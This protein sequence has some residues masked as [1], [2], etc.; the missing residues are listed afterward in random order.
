MIYDLLPIIFLFAIL[1]IA[2]EEKIK[3][4]KSAIMIMSA[5]LLWSLLLI[6][7]NA[8]LGTGLNKAYNQFIIDNPNLETLSN[9]DK[10]RYY[11]TNHAFI[12]NLGEVTTTLFFV[13]G[14]MTIV[15][16]IQVHGGF[17]VI[18]DHLNIKTKRQFAWAIGGISFVS[19]M[20]LDD[21]AAA[22]IMIA[23]LR[24]FFSTPQ[25]RM[26]YSCLVIITCNAGG[27]CSPIGD[28]TTILLW[29]SGNISP[30]HQ[31]SH[32]LIPSL[33][34]AVVAISLTMFFIKK[35]DLMPDKSSL[36]QKKQPALFKTKVSTTLLVMG[37]LTL[38]LVPV[39]NEITDLPPFMGVMGGLGVMWFYTDIIYSKITSI[40]EVDR[41]DMQR[42]LTHVDM[43]TIMFFFGVL[44]SVAALKTAGTLTDISLFL[45]KNI[46]DTTLIAFILGIASSFLDNVALVA[47]TM[48]MYPL[49]TITTTDT[50]LMVYATNSEFW[51]FIAYC[52]VTGGSIL[53]IG[54]A[55][56]VSVMGME[57]IPFGYYLK[58]FSL[59][60]FASYIAGAGAYLLIINKL[61]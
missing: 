13:I 19:S 57:K 34:N 50:A 10:Y 39:F 36:I 2:F 59:I 53:I 42:I 18:S 24:A 11:L 17:K 48:G 12:D 30:L 51:T 21:L 1:G 9:I 61:L 29:T 26:I 46:G 58:R 5:V 20:V 27:A 44:M 54:S 40:K 4:N 60:A 35:N 25:D 45:E 23:I 43:S 37:V 38:A 22:I 49:T 56:G 8:I 31:I 55:T 52:C 41:Q 6:D 16:L 33:V 3:I 28:V 7:A 47:A 14:S 15:E 32:L